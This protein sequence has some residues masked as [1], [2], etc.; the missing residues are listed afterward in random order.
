VKTSISTIVGFPAFVK[1]DW[2]FKVSISNEKNVLIIAFKRTHNYEFIMR[3]FDDD[4]SACRW[5][6]DL[7]E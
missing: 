2:G 5:V 7:I 1:G 4:E 6:K 3:F